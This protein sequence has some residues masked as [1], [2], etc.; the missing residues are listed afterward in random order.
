MIVKRVQPV[1]LGKMLGILYAVFG[2]LFGL[3]F[4]LIGLASSAFTS[5][6]HPQAFPGWSLFFGV[7]AVVFLPIMYGLLGFLG[8]LLTAALY[9]V[10]AKMIGGIVIEV[11]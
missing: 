10:L 9:N 6:S 3:V 1:P 7:G 11:E 8:G 4:S 2:L 5:G